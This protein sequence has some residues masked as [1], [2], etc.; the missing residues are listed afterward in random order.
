MRFEFGGMTGMRKKHRA[1][2]QDSPASSEI[3]ILPNGKILAHNISPGLAQVLAKLNPTDTPMKR[4][5][6]WKKAF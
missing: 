6:L 4:R 5:A 1:L 2:N 3:L